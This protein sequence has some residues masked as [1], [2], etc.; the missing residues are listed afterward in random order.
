MARNPTC[1][2]DR[3]DLYVEQQD[4][5]SAVIAAVTATAT[6]SLTSDDLNN[7]V[8][9]GV[10]LYVTIASLTVN[11]ATIGLNINGKDATTDLYY[12]VARVSIDGV[13]ASGSYTGIV[14]PGIGTTGLPENAAAANGVIPAVFQVQASLTISTTAG[15]SGT[16][17][18]QVG[19][20]KL[21]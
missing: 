5:A 16:L 19:M 17:G 8:H 13:A 20:C 15:M 11:T 14:Y 6:T 4:A 9:R 7:T 18:M 3:L 10:A 21:L 1:L 12:P 2:A